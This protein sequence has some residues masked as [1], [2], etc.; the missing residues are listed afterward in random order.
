AARL[1]LVAVVDHEIQPVGVAW[2]QAQLGHV[3]DG[4]RTVA[5]ALHAGR[6]R[7]TAVQIPAVLRRIGVRRHRDDIRGP[8]LVHGPHRGL[9]GAAYPMWRDA[10]SALLPVADAAVRAV[11]REIRDEQRRPQRPT[12]ARGD[13]VAGL[14]TRRDLSSDLRV[15]DARW[16]RG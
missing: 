1:V 5:F 2:N 3:P 12:A 10:G 11:D 15:I 7:I 13:V 14:V 9:P 16:R 6:R 4:F 8:G